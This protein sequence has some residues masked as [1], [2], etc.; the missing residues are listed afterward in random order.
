[1]KSFK[2]RKNFLMSS[3][4]V[5]LLA[6][7]TGGAAQAANPTYSFNI[8]AESLSQAL[9]D[10]SQ[11]S[12]Q[13]IIYSEDLVRGHRSAGLHGTFTAEQA[14]G[15]L[16]VG[17]DLK[18]ETNPAGVLM[19][20]PK[21]VQA[22][23]T[24][25]AAS[26]ETVVVTGSRL[27][28]PPGETAHDVKTYSRQ[29]LDQSG[30][31]SVSDFLNTLPMVSLNST[32]STFQPQGGAAT[33]GGTTV[34]LRGLP[35]GT[36]LVLLNGRRIGDTGLQYDGG[37][38]DLNN[39]PLAAID[40]IEVLPDGSSAIYGSD[41]I[42][43]VVNIIL[44]SDIEGL[45]SSVQY[46]GAKGT[47]EFDASV[48]AGG[49]WN[50]IKASLIGTYQNVGPLSA[51]DRPL[52]ASNDYTR[53]GGPNNNL[54]V[55][56]EA[57]VFSVNGT[58]LPGAPTGSG[59]TYA[60]LAHNVTSGAPSLSNFNYG[61]L[62][63]CSLTGHYSLINASTTEGLLFQG[64]A[65][66]S[67]SVELFTELLYSHRRVDQQQG[68][69]FL[70]GENGYQSYTLGAANPFN[71]F[72]ED[73]GIAAINPFS[74]AK[75]D[76]IT[77]TD[78]VRALVGLRGE[79]FTNW[80]WEL[81]AY[82]AS[83]WSSNVGTNELALPAIQTALD[84][85]DPSTAL[86]PFS[87]TPLSKAQIQ[88]YLSFYGLTA[89]G[90]EL[91]VDGVLRG[92]AFDLP[93]GP[94]Q[95]AIG[96]EFNHND[97]D[98]KFIPVIPT[99][100]YHRDNYSIFTEWR[101]PLLENSS[102]N[103]MLVV[104]AAGRYDHYSDFGGKPTYEVSGEWHPIDSLLIR[105][106]YA[107]AFKAPTLFELA[108]PANSYP[109]PVVNPNTG[110]TDLPTIILG[111]NSALKALVGNSRTIGAV[112][113][114]EQVPGL[115]LSVTNWNVNESNNVQDLPP[116]FIIDNPAAF[117]GRVTYDQ[118]GRITQ[119][120]DTY[121]NFGEI[122]VSGVDYSA[123]YKFETGA[124]AISPSL[125]VSQVY[126]YEATLTPGQ[127]AVNGVSRA[128]DTGDWAPRWKGALGIDFSN[129]YLSAHY[130]ERYTG[131]Y[132]DYDSTRDIG[133]FL[134]ADASI[135]LHLSTIFPDKVPLSG[136]D[137]TV[138]AVNLFNISPQFSN[139]GYDNT[140]YDPAQADIRGRYLYARLEATL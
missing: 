33:Y 120:L 63:T 90:R 79:I 51:S 31:V 87:S 77:S 117:P 74:A 112:W 98:I 137:L 16:L 72:G 84:S 105:S 49:Q 27:A 111:G 28:G 21:N 126:E 44:K 42:A 52:T 32:G 129:N 54:P 35:T 80:N 38:F 53:F 131:T 95:V 89:N 6:I 134:I 70:F 88:Q 75:V 56:S 29:D 18:L 130:D 101:V 62:N 92:Q 9:T 124:G 91:S 86:N 127:P 12:S 5:G 132:Q 73:V 59:D 47:D 71:P 85:S 11:A 19:V 55:C 26:L 65:D 48:A 139:F 25:E 94:A 4:L 106:T 20:R 67:P 83:D 140:G 122:R 36:T 96:G 3:A 34:T 118:N 60:A 41:A 97:L 8:P 17:T 108:S 102:G 119:V 110:S 103:E 43:G 123:T 133:N 99:G 58:P 78:F 136:F 125:N 30:Q 109:E 68:T 22:A 113:K 24:E 69:A 128:Q 7:T 1:M 116:Q 66:L 39:L 46:G 40:R 121:V 93:A 14:L 64:S 100:T 2:C 135:K 15:A 114:S 57:N 23:S 76:S 115:T 61:S 107:T 45:S 13:Q 81:T 138:G 50:N 37:F 82:D 104:S 10:F